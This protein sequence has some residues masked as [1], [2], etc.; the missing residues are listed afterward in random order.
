MTDLRTGSENPEVEAP[1][2]LNMPPTRGVG[3]LPRLR[4]FSV[5]SVRTRL[6]LWNVGS[7]AFVLAILGGLISYTVRTNLLTSVDN[8]LALRTAR[9]KPIPPRPPQEGGPSGGSGHGV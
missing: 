7:M 6:L 2:L 5:H 8:E 3:L 4:D 9:M 1:D